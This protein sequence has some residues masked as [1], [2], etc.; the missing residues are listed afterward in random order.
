MDRAKEFIRDGVVVQRIGSSLAY[1]LI[2]ADIL[3]DIT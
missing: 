3:V 2:G 1:N